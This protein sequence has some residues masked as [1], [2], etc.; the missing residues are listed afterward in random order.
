MKNTNFDYSKGFRNLGL[1][2]SMLLFSFC[3]LLLFASHLSVNTG[4]AD[5]EKNMRK[6]G[7]NKVDLKAFYG[8]HS[9]DKRMNVLDAQQWATISNAL[10]GFE[11]NHFPYFS[12]HINKIFNL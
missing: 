10:Y 9:K 3:I 5:S 8:F 7:E 12:Q 1:K 2:K 11:K 6:S 4:I